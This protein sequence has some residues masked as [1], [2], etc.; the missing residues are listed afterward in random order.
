MSDDSQT[1]PPEP[2]QKL[3]IS[4]S[5]PRGEA[6]IPRALAPASKGCLLPYSDAQEYE[7][8]SARG[9]FLGTTQGSGAPAC[10]RS[11]TAD[12]PGD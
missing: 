8:L 1:D 11:V 10:T 12:L 7:L 2:G 4:A 6:S 5:L 9:V 3:S